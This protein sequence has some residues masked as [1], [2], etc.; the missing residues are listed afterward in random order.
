MFNKRESSSPQQEPSPEQKPAQERPSMS[1]QQHRGAVIGPSIQIDGTLKG[2]ED[3]LIQGKVEGTIE[4]KKNSVTI[5][6]SGEVKADIFAHTIVVEGQVEGKIVG[7]ERVVMRKSAQIRG[8]LI[9]PRVMLEDGA[10]FN[11]TIDM[12]PE[13]DAIKSAFSGK[14][15]QTNPPQAQPAAANAPKSGSPAAESSD[16]R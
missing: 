12:D 9:A 1:D 16:R 7:S 15:A 4:L 5:G 13:A 8:T 14:S 2:D 6:E 11:G 10:R 3:L